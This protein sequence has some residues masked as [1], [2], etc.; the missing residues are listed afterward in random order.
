[1]S[2]RIVDESAQLDQA[3]QAL[4]TSLTTW[5]GSG[6]HP[7]RAQGGLEP[8]ADGASFARRDDLHLYLERTTDKIALGVALTEKDRDLLRIEFM[9]DAPARRKRRVAIAADE[10]G[11]FHLLLSVEALADQD[12]RDPVR[13][14]AGAPLAKRAEIGGRDFILLGP[15]DTPRIADSLAAV[16]GLSPNFERHIARLGDLAA[17]EDERMKS[18]LYVVSRNVSRAHK[19]QRRV[20]AALHERLSGHGF[21]IDEAR[22]GVLVAD[23]AMSRGAET[24][25]F[26]VRGDAEI[27]DL[28]RGVGQLALAAPRGAAL[29]RIF[30]LP[31]PRDGLGDALAPFY[32]ALEELGISVLLYDLRNDAMEFHFDRVDPELAQ[33]SRALFA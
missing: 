32:P 4:L 28:V 5:A 18:S 26:E 25:V 24:L 30:V 33:A 10:A 31:A 22:A 19:I 27:A 15:L 21:Q 23:F 14:L 1:M 13:R 2:L 17:D 8:S 29:T 7:W 6:A 20:I 16:A 11:R 9:R 12:I 3:Y